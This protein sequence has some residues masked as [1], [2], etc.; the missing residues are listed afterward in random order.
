[1]LSRW[2]KPS[3]SEPDDFHRRFLNRLLCPGSVVRLRDIFGGNG[4]LQVP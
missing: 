1:M 4:S 2:L 3:N